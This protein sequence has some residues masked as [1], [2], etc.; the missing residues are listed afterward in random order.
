M[1]IGEDEEDSKTFQAITWELL[2]NNGQKFRR[3]EQQ[4]IRVNALWK[5]CYE[6]GTISFILD[7]L[8][9]VSS[10]HLIGYDILSESF[11]IKAGKKN[12]EIVTGIHL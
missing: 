5:K 3:K 8:F 6:W 11:F 2:D 9:F 7:C 12:L 10:C 1:E 4:F